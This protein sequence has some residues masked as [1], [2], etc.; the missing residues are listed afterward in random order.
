[1][2]SR[3]NTWALVIAGSG[4]KFVHKMTG[5]AKNTENIF[6]FELEG[7][8][9]EGRKL[10]EKLTHIAYLLMATFHRLTHILFHPFS[11]L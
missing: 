1:M 6:S 11:Q 3:S 2:R 9:L 4:W 8:N 7:E 5:R 10:A